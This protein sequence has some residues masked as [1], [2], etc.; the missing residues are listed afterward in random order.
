M[1]RRH[2]DWDEDFEEDEWHERN[3]HRQAGGVAHVRPPVRAPPPARRSGAD[4][5]STDHFTSR[6]RSRSTGAQPA[7]NVKV[8]MSQYTNNDNHES[9]RSLSPAPE[10]PRRGASRGRRDHRQTTL[11]ADRLEDLDHDIRRLSSHRLTPD[12]LRREPSPGVNRL[13]LELHARQERVEREREIERE[14]LTRESDLSREKLSREAERERILREMERERVY[15]DRDMEKER[16][17][18]ERLEEKMNMELSA[19][20]KKKEHNNRH[21]QERLREADWRAAELEKERMRE[22]EERDQA[23]FKKKL[24]LARLKDRIEREEEEAKLQKRDKEWKSR[25]EIEK[26][27]DEQKRQRDD[28][29]RKEEREKFLADMDKKEK[30]AKAERDR[31]KLEIEAKER[32]DEEERQEIL[33]RAELKRKKDNEKAEELIA[34][35]EMQRKKKEDELKE[36]IARAEQKKRDQEAAN[37]KREAEIVAAHHQKLEDQ[38]K[39]EAEQREKFR[40]EDEAKRKKAKEEEDKLKA[41]LKEEEERA[42]EKKKADEKKLDEEMHR[43]LAKFGFQENQIEAV[44]DPKK[45]ANLPPG[46]SPGNPQYGMTPYHRPGHDH[47]HHVA[48]PTYIKVHR[49]HVDVE[50]LQY[51]RLPWEYDS[52]TDYIV[53]L[54]EMD[55]HETELLF[56]H[57][58]KL[59][60]GGAS[61][62][63]E[64]RGRHGHK[65]LAFVRRRKPSAS[66]SR[67]KRTP[68]RVGL[69]SLF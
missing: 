40:L 53:I 35:A 1:A 5:L 39:K 10:P 19:L 33:E 49:S 26:L 47:F 12:F 62:L 42:K 63:I 18:R 22:I 38:K 32:E 2:Q 6:L 56:E 3:F 4:L 27:K 11:V 20:K 65:D 67:R 24:E 61:L 13:E 9:D 44:L 15:H 28:L 48:K 25:L 14:R 52:D 30:A 7:P 59:R 51:F 17:L 37:K 50:T 54:Q 16:Y 46:A 36:I 66:P 23:L 21:D 31:I 69:G 68:V 57:T 29:E 43:R 60:R 45:A 55:T 41:K 8:Y 58:R 64:D 34:R